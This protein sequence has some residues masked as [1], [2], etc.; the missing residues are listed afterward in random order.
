MYEQQKLEEASYFYTQMLVNVGDFDV[1]KYNLSAFMS[2]ARSVLQYALSEA[3]TKTDGQNWYDNEMSQNEVLKFFKD[4]RDT[5]I[6]HEPVRLSRRFFIAVGGTLGLS[7]AISIRTKET[8]GNFIER[9]SSPQ[10]PLVSMPPETPREFTYDLRFADGSEIDDVLTLSQRY[11]QDLRDF[12]KDG[13]EQ[14][15]LTS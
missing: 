12:V 5:E 11:L 1:F 6:H 13:I 2:S 4:K 7:S 15:F 8:N 14:R 3:Q 10:E 9:Y